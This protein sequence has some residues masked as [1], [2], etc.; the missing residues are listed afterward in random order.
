MAAI[1]GPNGRPFAKAKAP[2]TTSIG[3]S[4]YVRFRGRVAEEY[5]QKLSGA[6][7][8][9]IYQKMRSDAMVE[10]VLTA[11]RLPIM[12]ASWT[13]EA[14]GRDGNATRARDLV[15]ENLFELLGECWED[16][17]R[18][19]LTNLI[20][21]FSV[22]VKQWKVVGGQV[23]LADL[24]PVHPRTILQSKEPWVID[25]DGKLQ[26]CWQYGTDG[27]TYREEWLPGERILHLTHDTEFRNPEGRS[28]LRSAY[29][30]WFIKNELYTYGAIG[31][32][33]ASV[34][35]PVGKYPE[36]TSTEK[37]A[38][39]QQILQ[40]VM[41]S[42]AAAV[43]LPEGW[44]VENFSLKVDNEGLMAQ[45]QHHDTK[46][47]QAVLAQFLQLGV[48]GKGGAYSLSS[49]QTDLFLLCLEA[50][51]DY[52][53]AKLNRRVVKEL[54]N[55]NLA[56]DQYPV[57]SATVARQSAVGLASVLRQLTAGINPLVTP[58]EAL[59]DFIRELLQLP[60][61][62][63][64]RPKPQEPKQPG[65]E[66]DP[67]ADADPKD[68][69]QLSGRRRERIELRVFQDP[70]AFSGEE[71]AYPAL[72]EIAAEFHS[73]IVAHSRDLQASVARI[74]GLPAT[75]STQLAQRRPSRKQAYA[76]GRLI[77]LADE[78][79]EKFTLSPEQEAAVDRAIQ[80]FITKL[81]GSDQSAEG[82]AGTDA[83]D[84]TLQHYER[85]A[86]AVGVEE[87]RR[88]TDAQAAAFQPTRESP[89][90][91]ALLDGAFKRLS[92]NG[93]LRLQG[94]L[95]GIKDLLTEGMLGGRS[96]LDVAQDL[97]DRFGRY[98]AY[99]WERLARTEAAFAATAGQIDEYGA[100]GV[101]E[102]ENLVSPLAC[103][104]CQAF[105]G[106]RVKVSEAIPG[107][108]V[109]P[110]HPNCLDSTIPVLP[111]AK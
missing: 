107:E 70:A 92:T 19:L 24:L 110:F 53:C 6:R 89:E 56:T 27:E 78:G 22:S 106:T 103:Q 8:I 64:P 72:G 46:I 79:A 99:E 74:A 58:D 11:V 7:K 81:V 17:V 49:D 98:E 12:A 4:G 1:L 88:L 48:E 5:F 34:G 90:I 108:N 111:E 41:V 57:V 44:T 63:A 73:A 28:L 62:T 36:G 101:E 43:T 100:E 87:A 94:Q 45:I 14:A 66:A 102:L 75:G 33:R 104:I 23:V 26:G 50:I 30:H 83:E 82:F 59:E 20:Y 3:F 51:A 60:A 32:E 37:Q 93:Q 18:N 10:A 91:R 55:Y 95:G 9:D 77:R 76:G 61:R 86:H 15:Q 97:E 42:D 54:V 21:G 13:V 80:T 25:G 39:F 40:G 69:E 47:A 35:T 109:A 2:D 71:P 31:A 67:A 16:E 84:A 65:Q 38:E 85:L 52:L 68:G 29:K 96:P 105:A